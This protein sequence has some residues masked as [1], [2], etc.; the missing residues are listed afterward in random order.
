[1]GRAFSKHGDEGDSMKNFDEK[2][3]GKETI[4]KI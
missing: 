4:S 1:M 3:R 2:A